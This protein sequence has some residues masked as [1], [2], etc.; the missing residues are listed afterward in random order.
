MV[1][2]Q[3]MY[4]CMY[5]SGNICLGLVLGRLYVLGWFS[6]VYVCLGLNLFGLYC[7]VICCVT[8]TKL[9]MYCRRVLNLVLST[10]LIQL[11]GLCKELQS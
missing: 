5:A 4:A 2:Q 3:R 11:I 7:C 10:E 6:A 8:E 9:V 1:Y